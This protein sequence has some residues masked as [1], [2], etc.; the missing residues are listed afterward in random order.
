MTPQRLHPLPGG[1]LEDRFAAGLRDARSV[2]DVMLPGHATTHPAR[3]AQ[4][5]TDRAQ[6]RPLADVRGLHDNEREANPTG[7]RG[8]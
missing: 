1:E 5:R 3:K 2:H 6:A 8:G 4:R 7:A